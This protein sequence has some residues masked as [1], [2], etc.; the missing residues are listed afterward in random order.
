[1]D[2]FDGFGAREEVK[3]NTRRNKRE[4]AD[5]KKQFAEDSQQSL[6]EKGRY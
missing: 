5:F 6:T 1:V 3:F 4:A 2:I